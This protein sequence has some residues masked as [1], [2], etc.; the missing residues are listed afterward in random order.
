M[1]PSN[2]VYENYTAAFESLPSSARSPARRAAFDAF[3]RLGLPDT[4]IEEWKYTDLSALTRLPARDIA[5][6]PRIHEFPATYD[7]GLDALNAALAGGRQLQTLKGSARFDTGEHQRLRLKVEADA[8]LVLDDAAPAR[9]AMFFAAIEVAPNARLR[10]LR[11]QN[12]AADAQRITRLKIHLARD[13]RVEAVTV[14]VGGALVRHDLDVYLEG[15][16]AEAHVSGLYLPAGDSHI[17][18]HTCIEHLAPH[19]TSREL[20]RGIVADRA[21]AVFNGRIV[22][23][24]GATKTDSEQ[25]IA[26]LLLSPQAQVNAKPELQIDN[27]DVKCAHGATCGQLDETAIY[28]LRSRGLPLEAARSVL[29]FTFADEILRRIPDADFRA[30]AERLVRARLPGGGAA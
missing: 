29:L 19:G 30:A 15:A 11:L 18:N 21:Q 17:D 2:D 5:P 27:D 16:G 24:P 23:H 7:C 6:N 3:A 14:D 10:L 1:L 13:A 28:Y 26:N 25:H 22:V 8:E 4:S 9:F 20:F 12:A